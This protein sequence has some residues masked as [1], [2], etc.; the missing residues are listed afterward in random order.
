MKNWMKKGL[1]IVLVASLST[2]LF[3][4]VSPVGTWD[5]KVP[6]APYEYQTGKLIVEKKDA[7]YKVKF[8]VNGSEIEAQ[9]VKYADS[10]L[11]FSTYVEGEYVRFKIKVGD[12]DMKGT[13]SYSEGQMDITASKKKK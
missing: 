5:Y 8:N 4:A 13:V 9:N 10:Q 12:K 1:V 6:S 11:T 3:A 7:K 2:A